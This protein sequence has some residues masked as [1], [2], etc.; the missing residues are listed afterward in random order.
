[1]FLKK[2]QTLLIYIFEYLEE[3]IFDL[4]RELDGGVLEFI[5]LGRAPLVL[6]DI[7]GDF[8][9]LSIFE[10]SSL[11]RKDLVGIIVRYLLCF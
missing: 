11:R 9:D 5:F 6:F 3:S 1:M 10:V 2:Y 7:L 8:L 4:K